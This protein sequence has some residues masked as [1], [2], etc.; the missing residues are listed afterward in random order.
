MSY[1]SKNNDCFSNALGLSQTFVFYHA[2]ADQVFPSS[3]I[4]KAEWYGTLLG[5]FYSVYEFI[6]VCTSQLYDEG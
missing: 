1:F 2:T 3:V 5:S 6:E 4:A